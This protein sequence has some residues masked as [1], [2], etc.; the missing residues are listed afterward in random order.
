LV[1]GTSDTGSSSDDGTMFITSGDRMRFDPAQDLS[2]NLGKVV[3][4]DR[5]GTIPKDN[6]FVGKPDVRG[7]TSSLGHRNILSAAVHPG[8]GQL[9]V[10]EMGP[11][12]GDELSPRRQ[13]ISLATESRPSAP[14]PG[15]KLLARD[16]DT[17][18]LT[19]TDKNDWLRPSSFT[20]AAKAAGRAGGRPRH[21]HGRARRPTIA[22]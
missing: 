19:V 16:P 21:R 20:A 1:E 3:R 22:P 6:P 18:K 8:T 14:H 13:S 5:D 2:S 11:L 7:D 17:H 10:A 12:G 4:I 9:R 15:V